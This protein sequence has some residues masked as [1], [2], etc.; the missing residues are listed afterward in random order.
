[1]HIFALRL[2]AR[3]P[4]VSCVHCA[5]RIVEKDRFLAVF[6][7]ETKP[8]LSAL[9]PF[10][11]QSKLL[12]AVIQPLLLANPTQVPYWTRRRLVCACGNILGFASSTRTAQ[13]AQ[14]AKFPLRALAC[15]LNVDIFRRI[16]SCH[17]MRVYP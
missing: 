2:R 14:R 13:L 12:A 10:S 4:L 6:S 7:A 8:S 15:L 16:F 1:M 17:C 11:H 9:L 3:I 5:K